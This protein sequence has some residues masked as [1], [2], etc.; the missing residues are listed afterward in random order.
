MQLIY[1][2]QSLPSHNSVLSPE[3]ISTETLVNAK[4]F[5]ILHLLFPTLFLLSGLVLRAALLPAESPPLPQLQSLLVQQHQELCAVFLC[6][7]YMLKETDSPT[8]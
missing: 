8:V 6:W 4:G 7:M 1:L 5:F 2:S 3:F